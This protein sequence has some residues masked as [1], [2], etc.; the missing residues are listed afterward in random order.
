MSVCVALGSQVTVF[1]MIC[2]LKHFFLDA[3][4]L[5][6]YDKSVNTF[7]SQLGMGTD[8][9]LLNWGLWTPSLFFQSFQP[10]LA[11]QSGPACPHHF[12]VALGCCPQGARSNREW[13]RCA[14]ITSRWYQR[15]RD[16]AVM[17]PRSGEGRQAASQFSLVWLL[18]GDWAL[19]PDQGQPAEDVDLESGKT[20]LCPSLVIIMKHFP[21]LKAIWTFK[22][23]KSYSPLVQ[24]LKKMNY[25][26][27]I[28]HALS[29]YLFLKREHIC[30][31]LNW[32][33]WPTMRERSFS[34]P[35]ET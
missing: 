23:Q 1:A 18:S 21:K 12:W 30:R 22:R 32:R 28:I 17:P 31:H 14:C 5:S 19:Q 16:S 2:E 13:C 4:H 3:D 10:G 6:K 7:I 34:N 15:A 33:I 25:S 27:H 20:G 29:G 26:S 9:K 11:Q 35:E 24:P 8:P